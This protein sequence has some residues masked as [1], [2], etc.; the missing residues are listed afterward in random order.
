MSKSTHSLRFPGG[1]ASL[2]LPYGTTVADLNA[3]FRFADPLEK[4]FALAPVAEG[5][6]DSLRP[7]QDRR[8][9]PRGG[10]R[11]YWEVPNAERRHEIIPVMATTSAR[12]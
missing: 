10:S 11:L 2:I 4:A 9:P 3:R 8:V 6:A 1:S 5:L 12:A 7:S